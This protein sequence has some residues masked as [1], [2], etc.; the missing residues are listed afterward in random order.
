MYILLLAQDTNEGYLNEFRFSGQ[1]IVDS[2]RASYCREVAITQV[3]NHTAKIFR[4][5]VALEIYECKI[6]KSIIFCLHS[7]FHLTNNFISGGKYRSGKRVEGQSVFG[8]VEC[9]VF[10]VN[11]ILYYVVFSHPC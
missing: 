11:S 6:G 8:G 7:L 9:R 10:H 1:R 5:G 3:L 4:Q 2:D